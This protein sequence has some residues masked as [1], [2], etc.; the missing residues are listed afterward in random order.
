[1][2]EEGRRLVQNK[3]SVRRWRYRSGVSPTFAQLAVSQAGPAAFSMEVSKPSGDR[4]SIP[5]RGAMLLLGSLWLSN[6]W[7]FKVNQM[8]N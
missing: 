8:I 6:H 4:G 1:M 7:S 2:A 5:C 3:Q